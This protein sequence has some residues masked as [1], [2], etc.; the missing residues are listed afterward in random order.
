MADLEGK[1][2]D[3][4][5]IGEFAYLS[6][7][8]EDL[9]PYEKYMLDTYGDEQRKINNDVDLIFETDEYPDELYSEVMDN[10]YLPLEE[11]YNGQRTW[12]VSQFE[13][14][15]SYMDI[16]RAAKDRNPFTF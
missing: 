10:M 16:Q 13:F 5:G 9:T 6:S 11:S 15:Y 1:T 12:D 2:S 7:E 3:D 8:E 14:E 4:E